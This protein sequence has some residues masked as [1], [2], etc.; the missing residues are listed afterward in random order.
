[1]EMVF[2]SVAKNV[3]SAVRIYLSSKALVLTSMSCGSGCQKLMGQEA[4][5]FIVS[6][7][8]CNGRWAKIWRL[9]PDGPTSRI[10]RVGNIPPL[11]DTAIFHFSVKHYVRKRQCNARTAIRNGDNELP[12]VSSSTGCITRRN[13]SLPLV[14]G[15]ADAHRCFEH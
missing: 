9:H 15:R 2:Q 4:D 12:M 13:T 7:T 5:K 3:K 14:S 11:T 10:P 1:M 8:G 6:L